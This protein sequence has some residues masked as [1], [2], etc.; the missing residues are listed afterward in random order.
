M[1]GEQLD[2]L[3]AACE[4]AALGVD[5]E[6]CALCSIVARC[7]GL[8]AHVRALERENAALLAA[9]YQKEAE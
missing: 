5:G 9:G 8:V 6:Q 4:G 2:N 3:E 7:M 1:T